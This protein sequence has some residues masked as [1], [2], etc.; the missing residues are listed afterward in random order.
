M[1]KVSVTVRVRFIVEV[2]VRVIVIG[3]DMV[4]AWDRHRNRAIIRASHIVNATT[5]EWMNRHSFFP[6]L[7]PPTPNIYF[8]MPTAG[9]W[10][11]ERKGG[12][13]GGEEKKNILPLE[14]FNLHRSLWECAMYLTP[15]TGSLLHQSSP[16]SPPPS[17]TLSNR[18]HVYPWINSGSAKGPAKGP[19]KG[20]TTGKPINTLVSKHSCMRTQYLCI[21]Q[22]SHGG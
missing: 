18:P 4:R 5:C 3:R 13:G 12:E 21:Q 22:S 7:P 10:K 14:I 1:L 19:A 15:V 11:R 6:S 2:K 20:S 17:K 9:Q 8:S 16:F